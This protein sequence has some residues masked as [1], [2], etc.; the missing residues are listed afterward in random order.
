MYK[1]VIT[2]GII[3]LTR[4]IGTQKVLV[5]EAEYWFERNQYEYVVPDKIRMIMFVLIL[6]S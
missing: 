3:T 5:K 4:V 1:L 6:F 2:L